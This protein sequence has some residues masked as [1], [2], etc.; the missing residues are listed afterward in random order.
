MTA[1]SENRIINKYLSMGTD[2]NV[3]YGK[4]VTLSEIEEYKQKKKFS[5]IYRKIQVV[6]RL[7]QKYHNL[8]SVHKLQ[9]RTVR[10]CMHN[11]MSPLSAVSGYF[12]L[13]VANLN[14]EKGS[15]KIERYSQKVSDG[16]NEV[17]FLLEQL[18]EMYK[19]DQEND[20]NIGV[21][22]VE[23]NWL[24]GEVNKVIYNS[25]E[26]RANKIVCKSQEKP[27]FVQAELFQLKLM[28]YNLIT[29]ADKLSTEQ[30][31]LEVDVSVKDNSAVLTVNCK[32]DTVSD[33]EFLK[34]FQY[35]E[36]I[37]ITK[38]VDEDSPILFGLKTCSEFAEQIN[39]TITLD[40]KDQDIP[41]FVFSVPRVQTKGKQF[42]SEKDTVVK[43]TG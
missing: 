36:I 11:V 38:Y 3:G 35:Q 23:L 10:N 26:V 25:T 24:V 22:V 19:V 43:K 15:E 34:L 4:G 16:L 1:Y 17:G 39:G 5:A 7:T 20:E 6:E 18:H 37:Q 31:T 13:L 28:I 9:K 8:E 41:K 29:S 2:I 21:P 14:Q 30:S 33:K 27:V 40:I 42:D 12:E 32:G